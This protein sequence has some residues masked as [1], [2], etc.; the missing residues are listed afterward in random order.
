MPVGSDG[1]QLV[2]GAAPELQDAPSRPIGLGPVEVRCGSTTGKHE[3]VEL[4]VRVERFAH[5]IAPCRLVEGVVVALTIRE[6]VQTVCLSVVDGYGSTSFQFPSETTS[7]LPLV[8]LIADWSSRT[9]AGPPMSDAQRSASA[10][11]LLGKASRWG[12]IEKSTTPRVRSSGA[13]GHWTK[14]APIRGVITMLP[15]LTPTQT[16][17]VIAGSRSA[18]PDSRI[19]WHRYVAS[20]P[21][22]SSTSA[23]STQGTQRSAPIVGSA[24]S[25][26]SPNDFHCIEVKPPHG[27]MPLTNPRAETGPQLGCPHCAVGMQRAVASAVGL[28][29]RSTSARRMLVFVTPPDVSR[30][31]K[32]PPESRATGWS[33][34]Q[35]PESSEPGPCLS[36]LPWPPFNN[37]TSGSRRVR[38]V[39]EHFFLA[40]RPRVPVRLP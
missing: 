15:A 37:P 35:P 28:P 11:V 38:H 22:T 2:A 34:T 36:A 9:Y 4:R 26:R 12:K 23:S 32:I 17:S 29:N 33:G 40:S 25:S 10:I 8:T 5:R 31:F 7:T 14:S 1:D 30:S 21:S 20:P 6:S 27:G 19:Q 16:V 39:A 3:V 13:D 24:E 18:S